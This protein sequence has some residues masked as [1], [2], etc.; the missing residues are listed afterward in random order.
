MF[1]IKW[2]TWN[3][4]IVVKSA[5]MRIA[6][7]IFL[8]LVCWSSTNVKPGVEIVRICHIQRP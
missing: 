8:T 4:D 6:I 2:L 1:Y 7:I 5:V 3:E